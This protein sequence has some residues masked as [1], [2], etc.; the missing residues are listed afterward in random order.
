M[1]LTR[2]FENPFDNERLGEGDF[3]T[4]A[5]FHIVSLQ[6]KNPGGIYDTIL[7]QTIPLYDILNSTVSAMKTEYAQQ[8]GSTITTNSTRRAFMKLVRIREGLISATFGG[9]DSPQYQEF[10][11]YGLKELNR[12]AN[13]EIDLIAQR[14]INVAAI[15]AAQLGPTLQADLET[16]RQ[17]FVNA[18]AAQITNMAETSTLRHRVRGARKALAEQLL[19]NLYTIGLHNTGNPEAVSSYFDVNLFTPKRAKKKEGE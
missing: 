11:P 5:Q 14:L 7:A 18:R 12:A 2:Y 9:T 6:I 16:A 4:G 3:R 15:Y 1:D 10:F 17:A 19:R 13:A 8:Q